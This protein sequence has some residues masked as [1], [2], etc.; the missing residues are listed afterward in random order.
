M[1]EKLVRDKVPE[2]I[3]K[4]GKKAVF[5]KASDGEYW[6]MLKVK[7]KEEVEDFLA[8]PIEEGLVDIYEVMNAIY[9]FMNVKKENLKELAE[10]K[11]EE[12]G[13]FKERVV[14][15]KVE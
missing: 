12:K 9:D 6:T 10:K 7:L 4:E 1:E 13:S 3:E 8:N 15:K 5:R 2:I 11:R 14:L